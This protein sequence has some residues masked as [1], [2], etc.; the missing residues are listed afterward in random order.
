M[1]INLLRLL[2][3]FFTLR[4]TQDPDESKL[5][6]RDGETGAN[7][8]HFCLGW[9]FSLQF[10]QNLKRQSFPVHSAYS[11]I[12]MSLDWCSLLLE[13]SELGEAGESQLLDAEAP[14]LCSSSSGNVTKRSSDEH[15][16]SILGLLRNDFERFWTRPVEI[17]RIE[18]TFLFFFFLG[19]FR[20]GMVL[21]FAV[22]FWQLGHLYWAPC[23]ACTI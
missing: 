13:S 16:E 14:L 6:P 8:L 23:F 7:S 15:W 17:F 4:L 9:Y 2:L 20:I 1:S 19:D 3:E 12:S 21:I 5:I 18:V 22:T 10:V 11:Y